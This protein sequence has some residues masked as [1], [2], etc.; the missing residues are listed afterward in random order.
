MSYF[1]L[2]KIDILYQ[3]LK[4]DACFNGGVLSEESKLTTCYFVFP[5]LR[6]L[7]FSNYPS[8]EQGAELK[9]CC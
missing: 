1:H 5:C 6:F 8:Q 3:Y 2:F 4:E 7:H 9:Y